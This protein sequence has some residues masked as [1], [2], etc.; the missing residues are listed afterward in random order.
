[1][2][3]V[4]LHYDFGVEIHGVGL[5]DLAISDAAYQTVRTEFEKSQPSS[6]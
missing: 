6:L 3:L 1:M 4:P 5:F 2:K